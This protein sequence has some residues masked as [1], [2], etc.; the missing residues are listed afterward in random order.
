MIIEFQ[1]L[2]CALTRM[3]FPVEGETATKDV[4]L[5]SEVDAAVLLA[6]LDLQ[7]RLRGPPY[8]LPVDL[9]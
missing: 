9:L 7:L 1:N 8:L 2:V 6:A 5:T 4:E 3:S